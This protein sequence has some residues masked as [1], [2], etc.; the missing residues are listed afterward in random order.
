MA[1]LT[2]TALKGIVKECLV[3][4]LAEGLQGNLN[5]S[6]SRR[7]QMIKRKNEERALQ[8]RRQKLET[9]IDTT[10]NTLTDDAV[11][12]SILADTARTTLQEQMGADSHR[13]PSSGGST[14]PGLDIDSI[15][16][17]SNN[18]WASLAFTDKSNR[19]P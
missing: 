1:K 14:G 18:N 2:K 19:L 15:F 13:G 6:N 17:E 3:E 8:E 10:V 11:M 7:Q 4:I 5:E 16:S 9:K 12:Q